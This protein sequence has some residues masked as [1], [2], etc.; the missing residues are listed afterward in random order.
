MGTKI[1]WLL[2]HIPEVKKAAEEGELM[3]G[4]VDSWLVWNLTGGSEG[5]RHLTDVTNASRTML[6]NISSLDWDS[7]LREFFNIPQSLILPTIQASSSNF[8]C[9]VRGPLQ[10]YPILGVVGD[11][12]AALL[13]QGCVN[14]GEA[15][16]TY[17]TGCF[18]LYNTGTEPVTSQNGLLT[19]VAYQVEGEPASYA[20][21]GSVAVAGLVLRW[22]RDNLH[23]IDNFSE[24]YQ[25]ASEVDRTGG[26][27]FV[28]AF[29]GLFA[30]HWRSVCP[31][32]LAPPSPSP[33][34]DARGTLCGLTG[35]T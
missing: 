8:G 20:L 14:R 28:P 19:T 15:K 4:T 3:F 18:M 2:E 5:G 13:G 31:L 32:Y 1:L 6:M 9:L 30:P 26:V 21:E 24:A 22:L 23:M 34:S 17:G 25:L 16:N 27:Y 29:S 11:Q 12:Q 10:G 33:R 7:S 35:H